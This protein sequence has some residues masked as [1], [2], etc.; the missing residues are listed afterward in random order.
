MVPILVFVWPKDVQKLFANEKIDATF[1]ELIR[2]QCRR[3]GS[4]CIPGHADNGNNISHTISDIPKILT[5]FIEY[6]VN[7][8]VKIIKGL[9]TP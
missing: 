9:F 2:L 7:C 1:G 4:I 8:I 3:Y 5:A 6:L